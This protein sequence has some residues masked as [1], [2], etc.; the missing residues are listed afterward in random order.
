VLGNADAFLVDPSADG[1]AEEVTERQLAARAWSVERLGADGLAWIEA[2][3][4]TVEVDL[5]G[6]RRL[7]ACHGSPGSYDDLI[8]PHT[9]EPE[10]RAFLDDVDV[11]VVAGGHTHLQFVRRR[12]RTLFV[13]P[14]SAGLSYDHEQPEDEFRLDPWSAYAVITT[15]GGS[16]SVELRRIPLDVGAVVAAF[17]GSG[18]PD[19][20]AWIPRWGGGR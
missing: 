4:P 3:P 20:E 18:H 14:G 10:F 16:F 19:A 5:G 2:L 8:F 6:G 13:N 11:D 15:G 1:S 7:L 9:P 17:R 12:G